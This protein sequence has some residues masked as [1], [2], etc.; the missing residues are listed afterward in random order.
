LATASDIAAQAIVSFQ[1]N[2]ESDRRALNTSKI[3]DS[4]EKVLSCEE[5]IFSE[6]LVRSWKNY[7]RAHMSTLTSKRR[8]L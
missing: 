2:C 1:G 8:A 5:S 3:T 7:V 4:V 6:A